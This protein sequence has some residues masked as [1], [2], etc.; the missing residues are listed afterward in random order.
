MMRKMNIQQTVLEFPAGA[1]DESVVLNFLKRCARIMG[2]T[3]STYHIDMFPQKGVHPIGFTATV[4]FQESYVAFDLWP[5]E[6]YCHV[7]LVSCKSFDE[8]QIQDL[9]CNTFDVDITTIVQFDVL[10]RS[11]P[12][13]RRKVSR[14]GSLLSPYWWFKVGHHGT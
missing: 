4:S 3:P 5:Q 8:L 13:E 9:I 11:R 10:E 1:Y 12:T 2:V 14:W 7:N 6:E